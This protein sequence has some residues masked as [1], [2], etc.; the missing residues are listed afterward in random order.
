V[1]EPRVKHFPTRLL[2]SAPA[3]RFAALFAVQPRWT[4]QQLDPYMEGFKVDKAVCFTV[5]T[6][7]C[8]MQVEV[9]AKMHLRGGRWRCWLQ[10][11]SSSSSSCYPIKP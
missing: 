9:E 3:A 7:L 2:P 5:C 10:A 8:S 6:K 11:W 1:A 4:R